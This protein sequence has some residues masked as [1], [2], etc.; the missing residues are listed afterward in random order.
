MDSTSDLDTDYIK[1]INID[2][3]HARLVKEYRSLVEPRLDDVPSGTDLCIQ[4]K[5]V[6]VKDHKK[7]DL[8]NRMPYTH[9]LVDRLLPKYNFNFVNYRSIRPNTAYN[10]HRD[11]GGICVHIPLVTN[12]GCW[13]V[14]DS[15]CFHMAA[16]G[17]VYAVNN[18]HWH[19]FVNSGPDRRVHLIFENLWIDQGSGL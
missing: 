11:K 18:S 13:F 6:L 2:I 9:S 4:K 15:K 14:Y 8:I 1:S 19:T 3:D 10:W 16:D 5:F 12:E 17:T 7:N